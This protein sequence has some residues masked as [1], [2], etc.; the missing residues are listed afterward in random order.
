MNEFKISSNPNDLDIEVVHSFMSKT[1]WAKNIPLETFKKS[2]TNSLVFGAYNQLGEQVGFAR[3]ITDKATFAY[4]G[5]VFVA[6][7]YRGLGISK[8][9]M[10]AVVSHP[11]LQGLRRFMLATS[12]AHGL[13]SQFGFQ[14]LKNPDIIMQIWQ[15]NIYD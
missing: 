15:P 11:D 5:D 9:L 1:S 12:D 14:S 7:L 2:I 10:Q 8:L 6:E 13:Y 3:V 4:L